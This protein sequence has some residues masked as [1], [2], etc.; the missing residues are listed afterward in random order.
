MSYL[1][2]YLMAKSDRTGLVCTNHAT[3]LSGTN[4][5]TSSSTSTPLSLSSTF[6]A[7]FTP[8]WSIVYASLA[9]L[10]I[11]IKT[12]SPHGARLSHR[13]RSFMAQMYWN[14]LDTVYGLDGGGCHH[15]PEDPAADVNAAFA[16]KPR[17]DLMDRCRIS[18]EDRMVAYLMS[19]GGNSNVHWCAHEIR[20]VFARTEADILHTLEFR[21]IPTTSWGVARDMIDLVETSVQIE[22][23]AYEQFR[24]RQAA[25]VAETAMQEETDKSEVD[26]DHRLAGPGPGPAATTIPPPYPVNIDSSRL[27]KLTTQQLTSALHD[28]DLLSI[29]RSILA[30]AAVQ[31]ALVQINDESKATNALAG[32][33]TKAELQAQYEVGCAIVSRLAGALRGACSVPYGEAVDMDWDDNTEEEYEKEAMFQVAVQSLGKHL[34]HIVRREAMEM[35]GQ[36]ENEAAAQTI[37]RDTE[38]SPPRVANGV[39]HVVTPSATSGMERRLDGDEKK[40]RSTKMNVEK[41]AKSYGSGSTCTADSALDFASERHHRATKKARKAKKKGVARLTTGYSPGYGGSGRVILE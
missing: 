12:H 15:H 25:M 33:F 24:Q 23:L 37:G 4:H 2:R 32:T 29:P 38:A 16:A 19:V 11:A 41:V 39:S 28:N 10:Q 5:S 20:E 9:C 27:T 26:K 34:N 31:N 1:D 35:A 30:R 7:T 36:N 3:L 6:R 17:P 14:C 8:G 22:R 40:N 18:I 21:L 13:P